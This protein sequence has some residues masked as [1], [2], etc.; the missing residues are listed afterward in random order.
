MGNNRIR[1]GEL[2]LTVDYR[3][4]MISSNDRNVYIKVR[5]KTYEINLNIICSQ[6]LL[7]SFINAYNFHTFVLEAR[8]YGYSSH[9]VKCLVH[10]AFKVS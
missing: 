9:N 5:F 1:L 2:S 8:Y 3:Y 4:F 10:S 7:T 6:K